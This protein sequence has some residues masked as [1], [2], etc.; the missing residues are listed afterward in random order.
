[1]DEEEAEVEEEKE[2]GMWKKKSVRRNKTMK[3]DWKVFIGRR[4]KVY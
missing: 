4:G 1:M 3:R 2:N